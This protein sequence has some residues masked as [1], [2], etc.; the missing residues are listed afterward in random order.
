MCK[1][2]LAT[3]KANTD[4]FLQYHYYIL[5]SVTCM[6]ST[7]LLKYR[8]YSAIPYKYFHCTHT[9][10]MINGLLRIPKDLYSDLALLN[11]LIYMR[12]VRQQ[13]SS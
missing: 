4:T 2:H 12:L 7:Q 6:H 3:V 1:H 5:A 10:K 9:L 13:S 11:I 8:M